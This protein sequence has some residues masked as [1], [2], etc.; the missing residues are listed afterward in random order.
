MQS[1]NFKIFLQTAKDSLN[2]KKKK[3]RNRPNMVRA[4][5]SF[6][7]YIKR[8]TPIDKVNRQSNCNAAGIR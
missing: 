2:Y 4:D 7:T 1:Q 5:G 3:K 8:E 6:P